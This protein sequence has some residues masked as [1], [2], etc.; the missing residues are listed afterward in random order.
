M[1]FEIEK[2]RPFE[3]N[4]FYNILIALYKEILLISKSKKHV[5][6]ITV[7]CLLLGTPNSKHDT[8]ILKTTSG[9][10]YYGGRGGLVIGGRDYCIC[11]YLYQSCIL[12]MFY[13]V[14]PPWH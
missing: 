1:N 13:I 9:V 10:Y 11:I 14:L 4:F 3:I 2:N 7:L 8:L 5:F 12:H 6:Y